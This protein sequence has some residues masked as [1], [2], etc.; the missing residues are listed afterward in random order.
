MLI[1][2]ATSCRNHGI[3]YHDHILFVGQDIDETA[4]MMA[5]VQ[6]SLL[7]CPG[8]IKVGNSLSDPMTGH[9]LFA[10]DGEDMWLTPFCFKDTWH[11][12]RTFAMMDS[13]LKPVQISKDASHHGMK[14]DRV[15]LGREDR[16]FFFFFEEA[17]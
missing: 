10:E 11:Y 14:Q 8:Y 2:A 5:Y 3:N 4:A 9:A 15:A 12:R 6:L 13:L 7:G 16:K 17:V 1:A